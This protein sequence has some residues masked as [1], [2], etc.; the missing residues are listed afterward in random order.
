[1]AYENHKHSVDYRMKQRGTI[2]WKAAQAWYYSNKM[3]QE[4]NLHVEAT[5]KYYAVQPLPSR[6]ESDKKSM[7]TL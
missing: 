6:P 7:K 2:P 1:M 5:Q 4:K 3:D